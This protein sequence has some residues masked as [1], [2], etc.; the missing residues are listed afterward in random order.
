MMDN[1]ISQLPFNIVDT[2]TGTGDQNTFLDI[3]VLNSKAT[4]IDAINDKY[5]HTIFSKIDPENNMP[6]TDH[7]LYFDD[8][9]FN[10]KCRDINN[11]LSLI[12]INICSI[13]KNLKTFESFLSS[14][15]CE[16][17]IICCSE[18]WFKKS[19]VD[20]HTPKNYNHIHDYRPTKRGGGTSIFIKNTIQ[21]ENRDDLKLDIHVNLCNSCFIEI[22]K[23]NV[24]ST[25]NVIIG[26]IYK[27]P[28]LPITQFNDIFDNLLNTLDK[29]KKDVYLLGD[30]NINT[31]EQ[32]TSNLHTHE[33]IN[34]IS[35]HAFTQ[36][37]NKPTRITHHSA[38]TIDGILTNVSLN[39][40]MYC[41]GIFPTNLFS[42]HFPIFTVIK[43]TAIK[44]RST[45]VKR[46]NFSQKNISNFRKKLMTTNWNEIYIYNDVNHAFMLF[47]EIMNDYMSHC[48]PMEVRKLTYENRL[49]W[50]SKSYLL[51][52]REK[53]KL[54]LE[55]MLSPSNHVLRDEYVKQ[56]NELTSSLKNAEIK[57]IS[58][59]LE[60]NKGDISK[61]WKII[62]DITG[63]NSTNTVTV[64]LLINNNMTS[65]KRI[66]SN[67][68]NTF[69]YRD[70]T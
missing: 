47:Q 30:F 19:T 32:C 12:H 20:R 33:F 9:T 16:F 68:F 1:T 23:C 63:L 22:D 8:L 3:N 35:A 7:S 24:N 18:S 60:M 31:G 42:D 25:R 26:C 21:Y 29:E 40:S 38:T 54:S 45:T 64:T 69:F 41:S 52:I 43:K 65:D 28:Q 27:A 37:I 17:S 6:N 14:L 13:P 66:I 46:R 11:M 5:D 44:K 34:I 39:N 49:P 57:Y 51:A 48:F 61:S 70:R 67:E 4:N 2:M 10:D 36:L 59:Q 50:M 55:S 58:N 56:K 62:K 15:K 53:N